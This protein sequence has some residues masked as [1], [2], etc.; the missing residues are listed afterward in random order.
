MRAHK[1]AA[2]V[3]VDTDGL[4]QNGNWRQL[5]RHGLAELE[6]RAAGNNH[7][8]IATGIRDSFCQYFNGPGAVAWQD[9]IVGV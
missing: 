6:A 9:A 5:P 8:Q 3:T 1:V 4:Q 2:E 7:A